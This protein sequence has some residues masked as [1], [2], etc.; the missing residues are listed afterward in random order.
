MEKS[1][2]IVFVISGSFVACDL[3][4][5]YGDVKFGHIGFLM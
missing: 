2:H 1:E 5:V 3:D 4:L